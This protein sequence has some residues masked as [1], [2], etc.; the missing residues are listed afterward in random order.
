NSH[1]DVINVDVGVDYRRRTLEQVDIYL[2]PLTEQTDQQ[3]KTAFERLA[4][5]ADENPVLEIEARKIRALR[6]AGS[7]IWFDFAT[8]CGGP[9]S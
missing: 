6:R 4:E 3:L 1:L 8:L 9:R 7:V 2:T 5:V